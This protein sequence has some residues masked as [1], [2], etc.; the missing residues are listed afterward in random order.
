MEFGRPWLLLLMLAA[1]Y[2]IVLARHSRSGLEPG[3]S[4]TATILRVLLLTALVFSLA[5]AR[6]V[7]RSYRTAT[8]FLLDHS[9][10]IPQ[11]VQARSVEWVNEQLGKRPEDDVAG[12]IL[13][14]SEAMIES[15]PSIKP[16]A[17]GPNSV[18]GRAATD[19]GAAIR[20][21]LAI[22]PEGYQR[23]IVVVSDGNENRGHALSE[24]EMA[25]AHGVTI[26]VLPLRYDYPGEVRI[27]RLHVPMEVTPREPYDATVVIH[28]QR[29]GPASLAVYRNGELLSMQDVEL[30]RGKNV[31]TV[32]QKVE[33]PGSFAYRAVVEMA[34]DTISQNNVAHAFASARGEAR[35]AVVPGEPVDAEELVSALQ[36]EGLHAVILP[37]G[38][39]QRG[40]I[41]VAA[42]DAVVFANV[43][44]A[45][46]GRTGM[47]MVESAVHD[48]GVGFV[49][50]GGE[51]SFGPGG[52]RGSPIEELLPVTMEQP[53]RR[54]MPNGALCLILHTVEIPRG[55]FW[56]KQIGLAALKVLNSKDFMGVLLYSYPNGDSWLFPMQP[57]TDKAKLGGFI[58]NAQPGDMPSFDG[59]LQMAHK[60]LK[61]VHAAS[62]HIV[63][64]SDADPSGPSKAIVDA[65]VADKISISTVAIGPHG[66]SDIA[67]MR[68]IAKAAMGRFYL[69]TDPSM[70]PQIFIKEAAT[71][72][73][74][75]VIEG[76]FQPVVLGYAEALKGI[77]PA[78]IPPLHGYTLT[79]PRSLARI[80]LGAPVGKKA[81]EG[82]SSQVDTL[83]AD[84][85]Y[86]LGRTVAFTSDAKAR[87]ARDWMAWEK[88]RKFWSQAVRSV[89]RTVPRSPYA[90]SAEIEGGKGRVTVDAV[91]A[92]GKFVHTL[93]FTGS[94][95]SPAGE[96]SELSFRQVGPGR[97][98]AEFD[99]DE[100]GVYAVA[101]SFEGAHGE[102]G[103]LS[104]GIPLAYAAEYRDLKTNE[105]LLDQIHERTGGRRIKADTEVYAPL[106][107]ASGMAKP[108]WPLLLML[109]LALW[110]IDV[111]IRRVAVDWGA[112]MRRI[113]A[114]V[115]FRKATP[116][117]MAV[118]ETIAALSAKKREVR[119]AWLDAPA[120]PVDLDVMASGKPTESA[121]P[122]AQVAPKPT[123][124]AKPQPEAAAEENDYMGQLLKARRKAKGD[125]S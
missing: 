51:R 124:E 68:T 9:F 113:G 83:L 85:T 18:V 82:E 44:A 73:R 53:Q 99:A 43:E 86:G 122:T 121:P 65:I 120:S 8:L 39:L 5:D 79:T 40:R 107:L 30:V 75:M 116:A 98:E 36:Q 13:F 94:V 92:E 97:Y 60:G 64:I 24:V 54:V 66:S 37:P 105:T 102:K 46:V 7:S 19:L 78:E 114:A 27:E 106:P 90:V 84:W 91:D 123:P 93:R 25:R 119:E 22:F 110:P 58:N 52:F 72:Q 57:V 47:R 62:K 38:E 6:W 96:K 2:F 108:L 111:F 4:V 15:P 63:V 35:V 17:V 20:L 117:P 112:M 125:K 67:K 11:E 3:R 42:F 26:D 59:T 49:M 23:R 34:G 28:S 16:A 21:A 33:Q 104:Q 88:Y 103:F 14:G 100:V 55:N 81:G 29:E 32:P 12:V 118:P 45:Q 77:L 10:S 87:W 48:A 50:I 61:G 31:Y 1:P 69:V 95:T 115:R 76:K 70:L 109:L 101:G 71:I 80:T 89:L 56:T 74:S 41:D